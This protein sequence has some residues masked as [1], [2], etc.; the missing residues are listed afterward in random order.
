[1]CFEETSFP[2]MTDTLQVH[3]HQNLVLKTCQD[4]SKTQKRGSSETLRNE[5]CFDFA[6]FAGLLDAD[7]EFY[8]SRQ[9][10]VSCELTLHEK[11]VQTLFFIKRHLGGSVT[12]R[13]GAKAY[14]WR[15]HKREPVRALLSHLNGLLQTQRTLTQ[16]K[17]AC[18]T[19]LIA[20]LPSG[21]ITLQDA[22]ISGFFSGDGSFSIN[23]AAGFQP[24]ASIAHKEK[25]VLDSMCGLLGGNVYFDS[26][27]NGW[28]WWIDLR[29]PT[30]L[31]NYLETFSLRNPLKQARF[32]S[33]CRFLGYLER[34]FH[35][36]AG[37]Q[38]RFHHFVRLFQKNQPLPHF[39]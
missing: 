11:E 28:V 2:L 25:S 16:F 15:L 4:T 17:R 23:R 31:V 37:S 3:D 29:S 35:R 21:E 34:G 6:W 19:F 14:R 39:Q 7:G 24:S 13:S 9:G 18:D 27:W 38:A 12:R 20:P 30:P 22:W 36:D 10:Y 33:I 26:S 32:K 8:L 1:M 5:S